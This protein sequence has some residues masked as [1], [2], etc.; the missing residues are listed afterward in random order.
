MKIN[1]WNLL[2][3]FIFIFNTFDIFVLILFQLVIYNRKYSI[4]MIAGRRKWTV[5]THTRLQSR[6]YMAASQFGSRDFNYDAS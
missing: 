4:T 3:D 6:R 2:Q 5:R 1:K